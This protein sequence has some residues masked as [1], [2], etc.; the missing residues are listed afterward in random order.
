M[1]A[2]FLPILACILAGCSSGFVEP[3]QP[4]PLNGDLAIERV[5]KTGEYQRLEAESDRPL[6][7]FT[8]ATRDAVRIEVQEDFDGARYPIGS[9]KVLQDGRVY[10]WDDGRGAWRVV[11]RFD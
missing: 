3:P 11:A 6:I 2:W 8:D 1:K 5:R 9:F 4:Q 10:I 7:L